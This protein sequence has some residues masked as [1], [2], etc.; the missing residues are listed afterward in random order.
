MNLE[1]SVRTIKM[2]LVDR[3]IGATLCKTV[4]HTPDSDGL[5][6]NCREY[7]RCV[8]WDKCLQK[9]PYMHELCD[10]ELNALND[11]V[12]RKK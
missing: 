1:Q 2:S 6:C 11:C 8:I 7:V 3:F 5:C 12:L 4:G 9:R 10:F